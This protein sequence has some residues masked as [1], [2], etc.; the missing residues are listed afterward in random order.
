MNCINLII[1]EGK[2]NSA[3]NS[4]VNRSFS[5]FTSHL[6]NGNSEKY[7]LKEFSYKFVLLS[8]RSWSCEFFFV[9]KIVFLPLVSRWFIAFS[10]LINLITVSL[11]SGAENTATKW[12]W[13][14]KLYNNVEYSGFLLL[15]L[16]RRKCILFREQTFSVLCYHF[17]YNWLLK[18]QAQT[19]WSLPKRKLIVEW[20][21]IA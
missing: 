18:F 3:I 8:S 5:V 6:V 4:W 20:F 16:H 13:C 10:L 17:H 19:L 11:C 7:L 12:F 9:L 2:V 15:N 21:T 14:Y 1:L